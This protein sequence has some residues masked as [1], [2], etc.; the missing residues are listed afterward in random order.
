M[1]TE[2]LAI[3]MS[4]GDGVDEIKLSMTENKIHISDKD[5][6]LKCEFYDDHRK[7]QSYCE[8][9]HPQLAELITVMATSM[10]PKNTMFSETNSFNKS[11]MVNICHGF[12]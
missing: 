6:Y 12:K 3:N 10:M 4:I 9:R 8:A 7:N 1:S 11:N 5:G 2:K